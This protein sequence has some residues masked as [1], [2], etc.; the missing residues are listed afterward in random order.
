MTTA[1]FVL[2][3]FI[4]VCF[5]SCAGMSAAEVSTVAVSGSTALIGFVEALSPMLRPE[6]QAELVSIAGN[7]D[8]VVQAATK[9]VG[10]VAQTV[11]E[12]RQQVE[13]DE[14]SQWTGGEIGGA[15]A[16]V[17]TASVAASR[18]L[19]VLKHRPSSI[20]TSAD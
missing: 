20:K 18:A 16:A 13:T 3:A 1:R 7:I 19:S 14:A 4:A 2:I 17:G 15:V 12:L 10:T 11:A 6:Q 5:T 9:A 8:T